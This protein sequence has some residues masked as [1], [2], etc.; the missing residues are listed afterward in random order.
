MPTP[1]L[2]STLSPKFDALFHNHIGIRA[3]EQD[4]GA[5]GMATLQVAESNGKA[6]R[7]KSLEPLIKGLKELLD[8]LP[9]T[10]WYLLSDLGG[11]PRKFVRH[12]KSL[13]SVPHPFSSPA[14]QDRST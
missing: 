12:K 8:Q 4:F 1:I 11:W 14:R 5:G 3:T 6:V 7:G 9:D 10:Q 2:T 13:R